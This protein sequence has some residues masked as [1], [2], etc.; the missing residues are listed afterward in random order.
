MP[1]TD[2]PDEV[3]QYDSVSTAGR[4]ENTVDPDLPGHQSKGPGSFPA[5]L[6]KKYTLKDTRRDRGVESGRVSPSRRPIPSQ[7]MYQSPGNPGG[8]LSSSHH[9]ARVRAP[10]LPA[11]MMN[12]SLRATSTV[13]VIN[14]PR[15][16]TSMIERVIREP[17]PVPV[18]QPPPPPKI[19]H[20]VRP[21]YIPQPP[22][23]RLNFIFLFY[24]LDAN[25][26][27]FGASCSLARLR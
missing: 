8:S 20:Q 15:T 2:D 9:G 26:G 10:A 12:G 11:H 25:F 19:I 21:V 4:R 24:Q 23:V 17:V 14:D 5:H 6:V 22:E 13:R 18:Y 1:G 3:D 7:F 27:A 16:R